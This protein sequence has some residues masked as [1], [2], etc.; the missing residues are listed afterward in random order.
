VTSLARIQIQARNLA[1]G[2]GDRSTRLRYVDDE[3]TH[4]EM[5]QI[6]MFRSSGWK[7]I[8]VA[9]VTFYLVSSLLVIICS[10]KKGDELLIEGLPSMMRTGYSS[11]AASCMMDICQR[12]RV[13]ITTTHTKLATLCTTRRGNGSQVGIA[14]ISVNIPLESFR[15][16]GVHNGSP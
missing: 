8:G 16:R 2:T 10:I 13:W 7:N 4:S 15:H 11:S 3:P 5:C 6:S 9:G 14:A 1:R 12:P